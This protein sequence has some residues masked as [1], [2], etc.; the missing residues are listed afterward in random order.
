[1]IDVNRIRSLEGLNKLEATLNEFLSSTEIPQLYIELDWGTEDYEAD[2][3]AVRDL[4]EKVI[5]RRE[6]LSKFLI[7]EQSRKSVQSPSPVP[8]PEASA[9]AQ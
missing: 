6:S 5:K 4:L 1:M 9:S 8:V 2:C 7:R 3:D